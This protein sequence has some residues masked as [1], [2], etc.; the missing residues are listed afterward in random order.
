[1]QVNDTSIIHIF[2]I[3]FNS[4]VL[5]NCLQTSEIVISRIKYFRGTNFR[6]FVLV[7]INPC[8]K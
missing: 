2:D 3:C 5:I 7:K 6:Y 1:M 4:E 8:E